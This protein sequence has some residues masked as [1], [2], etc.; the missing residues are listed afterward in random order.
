MVENS[1]RSM[2]VGSK[3]ENIMKLTL[4]K[5]RQSCGAILGEV[6]V[7]LLLSSFLFVFTAVLWSSANRDL[8]DTRN[9]VER[10]SQVHK[11]NLPAARQGADTPCIVRSSAPSERR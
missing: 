3:R 9:Y 8:A 5:N 11:W 7:G 6:M 1:R 10:Q 4:S 2:I